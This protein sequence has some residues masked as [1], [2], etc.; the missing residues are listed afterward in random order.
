MNSSLI[1]KG[2]FTGVILVSLFFTI[3][4]NQTSFAQ[5]PDLANPLEIVLYPENPDP[6]SK[7]SVSLKSYSI[8]VNSSDIS[9]YVDGK[10]EKKGKG[11]LN[12][13]AVSPA[14]GKKMTI[15]VEALSSN[16]RLFTSRISIIPTDLDILWETDG[17]TPP[18]YQGKSLYVSQGTVYLTAE[19]Q[20]KTQSGKMIDPADLTYKWKL[21]SQV[22]ASQSGRGKRKI[23]LEGNAL[24]KPVGATVEVTA[25]EYGL[26]AEKGISLE[27]IDQEVVLYENNPLY[28]I[29]WNKALEFPVNLINREIEIL[30]E[31]FNFSTQNLKTGDISYEWFIGN[32]E[33]P[34]LK[35]NKSVTLRPKEKTQGNS[36]VKVEVVN[37]SRIFQKTGGSINLRFNDNEN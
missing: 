12:L 33:Y 20:F 30:V 22:M 26:K 13:E 11:E 31:P 37:N 36:N 8:D 15:S 9:W 23:T 32:R 16:G 7:V 24:L 10:L 18:F 5:I 1:K 21:G 6:E 34:E 29:L 4:A 25:L 28:G 2:F 19:P 27:P 3:Q 35:N 17:Y 14:L